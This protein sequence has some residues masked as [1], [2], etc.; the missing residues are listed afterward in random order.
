MFLYLEMNSPISFIK[1]ILQNKINFGYINCTNFKDEKSSNWVV[2][3]LKDS[4]ANF[5]LGRLY[6]EKS[7]D[8]FWN[9]TGG[10]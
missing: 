8:C 4:I 7:Y 2:Y 9:S 3:V 1:Q 5:I 10:Y 6:S